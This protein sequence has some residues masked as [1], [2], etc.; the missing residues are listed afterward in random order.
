MQLVLP[1]FNLS[2]GLHHLPAL[3]PAIPAPG[4]CNVICSDK[5]GTLTANEMT[6]TR[7]LASDGCQAEV[8]LSSF[9]SLSCWSSAALNPPLV[10]SEPSQGGWPAPNPAVSV[11]FP[12]EKGFLQPW[13]QAEVGLRVQNGSG[14]TEMFIGTSCCSLQL[15]QI[16]KSDTDLW[17]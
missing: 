12:T 13:G 3:T 15:L 6:V 4:C 5:T 17:M 11:P 10:H 14:A 8:G 2:A 9:P 16:L 1:L 7:L